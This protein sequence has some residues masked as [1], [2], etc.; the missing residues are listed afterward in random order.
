MKLRYDPFQIF[1]F[2]KTPPGLYARQ[3]WLGQAGSSRWRSDF[4]HTLTQLLSDRTPDDSTIL[5]TIHRL[6]GLHLTVREPDQNIHSTIDRLLEEIAC[7]KEHETPPQLTGKDLEGLPFTPGPWDRFLQGATLF[8]AAIF[9][10]Q[11]DP[12]VCAL[13][14]R[15]CLEGRKNS[16]RW[17]DLPSTHNIF[18]AMVVHP[19]YA[20]DPAT[21]STVSLLVGLQHADF[22]WGDQLPF[23]QTV[24]AL[25]HLEE[26]RAHRQLQKAFQRLIDTQQ[27]DGTWGDTQAE[28][29]TFLVIHAL[30]N[31]GIL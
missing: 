29:N 23:Y 2:S 11:A 28:W 1:E 22:T 13:Y 9:G 3:K 18:R 17:D 16:G 10:R 20:K 31:K 12:K 4:D 15:L 6:F 7:I 14:D 8:L 25:A 26:P 5:K 19:V 21:V 24:N 27:T 30:K